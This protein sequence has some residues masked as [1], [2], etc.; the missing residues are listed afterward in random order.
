MLTFSGAGLGSATLHP[1]GAFS[2]ATPAKVTAPAS[3]NTLTSLA[4]TVAGGVPNGLFT[5]QF[6]LADIDTTV[7]PHK[8]ISRTVLYT[9]LIIRPAGSDVM[10]GRG[11]FNLPQMPATSAQTVATSPV[12]SGLV[13]LTRP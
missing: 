1:S 5:G 7:T 12:L 8:S 2:V 4:F 13:T 6:T 9:G 3:N 11:F 10:V